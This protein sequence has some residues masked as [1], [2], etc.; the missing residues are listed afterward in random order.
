MFFPQ[1]FKKN[2]TD[3]LKHPKFPTVDRTVMTSLV[4]DDGLGV[5]EADLVLGVSYGIH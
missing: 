5:A 1:F 4:A 3:L 2:I